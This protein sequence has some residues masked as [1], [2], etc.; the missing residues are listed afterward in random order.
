MLRL[1]LRLVPVLF[2]LGF[3]GACATQAGEIPNPFGRGD[4]VG[5]GDAETGEG[6]DGDGDGE[7]EGGGSCG[8]AVLDADDECD[9]GQLNSAT[10]QCTT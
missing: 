7:G 10:G 8:D 2:A 9:L 4:G 5:D 3:A 6:G 1:H